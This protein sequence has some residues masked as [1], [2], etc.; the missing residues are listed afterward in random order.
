MNNS[1][2]DQILLAQWHSKNVPMVPLL[3]FCKKEVYWFARNSFT[4]FH[5]T[6]GLV[7]ESTYMYVHM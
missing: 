6:T 7:H 1:S 2:A 5:E 4:I 3:H